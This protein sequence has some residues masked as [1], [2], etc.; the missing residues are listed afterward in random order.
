MTS[1]VHPLPFLA[2]AD[3][4]HHVIDA[5]IRRVQGAIDVLDEIIVVL[6]ANRRSD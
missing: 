1:G 2:T 4:R 6:E 3:V 5:S